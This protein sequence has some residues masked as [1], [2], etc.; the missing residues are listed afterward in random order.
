MAALARLQRSVA[1][2]L[3]LATFPVAAELCTTDAAHVAETF[4]LDADVTS[5]AV[6]GGE[7][8]SAL[9]TQVNSG[10][11]MLLLYTPTHTKTY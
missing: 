7:L 2:D 1:R 4:V 8:R 11:L 3:V 9:F 10:T 5:E 6:V